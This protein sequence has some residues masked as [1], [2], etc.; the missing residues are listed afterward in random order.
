MNERFYKLPVEIAGRRDLTSASKVVWA[1]LADRM[2]K[3]GFCWPG[4]RTLAKDVGLTVTGVLGCV[5]Q[6]ER[7]GF[8]AVERRGSG[9]AN[10]Y[11]LTSQSA[12]QARALNKPERSGKLNSGAQQTCAQA[13]NKVE[14]N[15]TD[16][17][18][19]TKK[20]RTDERGKDR[21]RVKPVG[22][23]IR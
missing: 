23:F 19:Q 1:A 21:D 6:L 4:V 15:Q 18:N 16:Q 22:E 10:H 17:L 12:Q 9:R 3:N 13:L 14:H 11:R 2:G 20:E 7:K 8:V 5:G